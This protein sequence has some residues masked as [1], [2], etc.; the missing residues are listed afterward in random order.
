MEMASPKKPLNSGFKHPHLEAK[1]DPLGFNAEGLD[2][3]ILS[4]EY[5]AESNEVSFT[6][7][8]GENFTLNADTGVF[9]NAEGTFDA[10]ESEALSAED[11]TIV[12]N[13]AGYVPSGEWGSMHPA[14]A[15]QDYQWA[16]RQC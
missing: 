14:E 15:N 13:A 9:K 2:N 5:D 10:E 1:F 6:T 16:F 4:A 12:M 3:D 8:H 7:L 11:L